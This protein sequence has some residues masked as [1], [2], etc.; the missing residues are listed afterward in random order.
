MPC[1]EDLQITRYLWQ[2]AGIA[3]QDLTPMALTLV[4]M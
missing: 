1:R 2:E 3:M 4:F